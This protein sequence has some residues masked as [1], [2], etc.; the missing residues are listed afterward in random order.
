M[1]FAVLSC[2]SGPA[3][4]DL[5]GVW[6]GEIEVQGMTLPFVL[7][8][9]HNGEDLSG[10]M[11]IPAQNAR[12][13]QLS[14]MSVRGDSVFFSLTSPAGRADFA[15]TG[16]DGSIAGSFL[17]AGYSGTFT[18]CRTSP[19]VPLDESAGEEVT[20]AGEDCVIAGTLVLPEGEP[21]YPCVF[22]LTGSGPQ[23][24]D[25]YVMGFPVFAV[26]SR[27]L[28]GSG[29]A[30][31]RCDDRGVGGSTG[32]TGS[33][34]DS[35]FLYEAG[36]MLDHLR[37]DARIDPDRIGVLGHSEGSSTAFALAAARPSDLAFVVSMA[38][39]SL[40][41]Y[42][43]LLAQQEAI[44][45]AHG[46]PEEE[47]A[48]KRTAQVRIMDA[49]LSGQDAGAL[50]MILEEHF[51]EDYSR[52]AGEE[53]ASMGDIDRLVAM[54]VQQTMPQVT[55]PWFRGFLLHDPA[56]NIARVACPVLVV[57]GGKD[58]QV[59]PEV[60]LPSMEAALQDNPDHEIIVVPEANHLFQRAVTGEVE[61]YASLPPEFI[62]G[63]LETV[64]SW[65][66]ARVF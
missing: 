32:D 12:N 47:I 22:L 3:P 37:S 11:D 38:G 34:G 29:L 25:E 45:T 33:L 39:P 23:D 4:L 58:I 18:V 35:V 14:H 66:A 54:S 5:N 26:L 13:L 36:L 43:T 2:G 59:I 31:L 63:F 52:L 28:S 17:Q 9:E 27:H 64:S 53:P 21:P 19:E 8:L 1:G 41:G 16:R 65:I 40:D 46:F 57:Y 61:E 55:S 30:V 24:R 51:R 6:E 20:I 50:Q 48:R 44:L 49:V 56:Q 62:E 10:N 15:G 42:S 60:N 7:R